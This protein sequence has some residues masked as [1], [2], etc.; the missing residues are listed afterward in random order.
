M[1]FTFLKW[2]WAN[3]IIL[4]SDGGEEGGFVA[5]SAFHDSDYWT[6]R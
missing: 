4:Q 6:E 5:A 3:I 2:V 1:N